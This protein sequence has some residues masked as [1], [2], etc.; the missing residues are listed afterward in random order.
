LISNSLKHSF[1]GRSAGEIRVGFRV[2]DGICTLT[3]DDDGSPLPDDMFASR[4]PTMGVRLVEAL[5]SQLGGKLQVGSGPKFSIAFSDRRD[6]A[7]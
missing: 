1:H 7:A 3:V 6:T 4:P 2:S 5:T